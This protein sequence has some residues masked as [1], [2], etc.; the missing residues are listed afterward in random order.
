MLNQI[1]CPICTGELAPTSSESYLEEIYYICPSCQKEYSVEEAGT[2][3]IIQ[4][5]LND[6]DYQE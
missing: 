5:Y 1:Y 6:N 2:N 3:L 4:T